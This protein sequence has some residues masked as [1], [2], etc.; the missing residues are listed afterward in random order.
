MNTTISNKD[1]ENWTSTNERFIAFVDIMGFKD[2]VAK[3]G[4]EEIKLMLTELIL[5]TNSVVDTMRVVNHVYYEKEIK[6]VRVRSLTFSDSIIFVTEDKSPEDFFLLSLTLS[7]FQGTSLERGIPIKGAI[8]CGKL[9][10]DFNLS[11]FFGQPLI[12]AYL[13]QEELF[14]YGIIVDHFVESF[15]VDME[16]KISEKEKMTLSA[17]K[18]LMT[19]LKNSI[20]PHYNLKSQILYPEKI[21][22][23]YKPV[24][25]SVR[26]YVDNTTEMLEKLK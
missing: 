6:E 1:F 16:N 22:N 25:G 10:A 8:S 19:P 14:Y 18:R 7:V 9:T 3:K 5:F 2:L 4:H 17:F 21:N 12:D 23:L 15:I 13:L 20:A 24:S 11:L 26:Q